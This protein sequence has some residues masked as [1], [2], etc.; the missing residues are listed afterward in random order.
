MR[1]IVI[2]IESFDSISDEP[3]FE[4]RHGLLVTENFAIYINRETEDVTVLSEVKPTDSEGV[5]ESES[6][7]YI[8]HSQMS[9]ETDEEYLRR[10]VR[11]MKRMS[12]LEFFTTRMTRDMEQYI[13]GQRLY[14]IACE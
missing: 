7:I 12:T 13:F 3:I 9:D 11:K 1:K 14:D 4:V 2:L 6:V 5:Y 10:I 8:G